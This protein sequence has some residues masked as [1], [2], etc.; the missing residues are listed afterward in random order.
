[1][2]KSQML[3]AQHLP[4]VDVALGA[5]GT[6]F[7]TFADQDSGC[8]SYGVE[9]DGERFFVKTAGT[10]GTVASLRRALAVHQVAA[11]SALI[12]IVHSFTTDDGLALVYPWAE[13]VVLYH[14]TRTRHGGR[15][16]PDSPMARFRQLP[17]QKV[18]E[19]LAVILD[20][21]LVVADAGLVAVDFY[22]GCTLYDFETGTMRLCDLDGYRPGPFVLE[23]ERLPGS[24]RYMAPE[25]FQRGAVIDQRTTVFN[26][27]RLLRLLLDGGDEEQD[28][29]GTGAQLTVI[30]T[31]TAPNPTDRYPS[32]RDLAQAWSSAC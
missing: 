2:P 13:G 10:A 31:A 4:S 15:S 24:T 1:M 25:E 3:T 9:I 26:L 18:H 5:A 6:V 20:V 22:D 23:A 12:P 17:L 19:A 21:H 30:T 16:H 7:R 32:V 29:R 27:G 11:H 28:W 14:P 8:V